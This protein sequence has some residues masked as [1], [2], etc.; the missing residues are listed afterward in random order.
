M[1]ASISTPT[2]FAAAPPPADSVP[3]SSI[4]A[5]DSQDA[6][7]TAQARPTGVNGE[8]ARAELAET[9][10]EAARPKQKKRAKLKAAWDFFRHPLRTL[11]QRKTRTYVLIQDSPTPTPNHDCR[12]S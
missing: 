12:K 2:P 11:R 3:V 7:K 4:V 6:R 8:A 10:A 1:I 9:T 5:K